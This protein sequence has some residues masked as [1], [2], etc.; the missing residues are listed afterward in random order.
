MTKKDWKMP[1]PSIG[2]I[3]LFSND[4]VNFTDPCVG[5]VASEPGDTTISILTFSPTGYALV[6]N[7]CHHKDDPA[8][9]GDHGWSDLGVWDFAPATQTLRELTDAGTSSG[10]KSSNK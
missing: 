3:V 9:S 10:R 2:D 1:V 8:L 6:H 5:F 7:S 4:I